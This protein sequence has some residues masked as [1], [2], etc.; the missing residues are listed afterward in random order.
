MIQPKIQMKAHTFAISQDITEGSLDM[1]S[2]EKTLF[3]TF[4]A[5]RASPVK[6]QNKITKRSHQ[7]NVDM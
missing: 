4:F 5:R 1:R 6:Q 3:F 7:M 2:K